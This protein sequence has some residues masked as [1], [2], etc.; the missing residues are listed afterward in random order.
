MAEQQLDVSM[1]VGWVEVLPSQVRRARVRSLG[2]EALGCAGCD[3][4]GCWADSNAAVCVYFPAVAAVFATSVFRCSGLCV[5]ARLCVCVLLLHLQEP[6]P[7]PEQEPQHE[8]RSRTFTASRS[9]VGGYEDG[10]AVDPVRIWVGSW[11]TAVN[12]CNCEELCGPMES[13]TPEAL[14]RML[15]TFAR[16]VPTDC[17]IYIMGLQEGSP[18]CEG[19]YF[20]SQLELYLRRLGVAHVPAA[21]GHPGKIYGRG[22]GSFISP[23]FTGIRVYCRSSSREH[24]SVVGAAGASAGINEGSK[25]AVGAL[26]RV[27]DTTLLAI[28]CHLAKHDMQKRRDQYGDICRK[29]AEGLAASSP[30]SSPSASTSPGASGLGPAAGGVGDLHSQYHHIIWFGDMNY[31][32][33]K[34][35]DGGCTPDE[36]ISCI[37]DGQLHALYPY[38]ELFEELDLIESPQNRRPLCFC[39]FSEPEKFVTGPLETRFY[40]TY[41]KDSKRGTAEAKG[42]RRFVVPHR[43][44]DIEAERDWVRRVYKIDYAEHW[45]KGGG[46]KLRMPSWTDRILYRSMPHLQSRFVPATR[47]DTDRYRAVNEVLLSSDHSPISCVFE[48]QPE[49]CRTEPHY[50]KMTVSNALAKYT[51]DTD[52]RWLAHCCGRKSTAALESLTCHGVCYFAQASQLRR[53][54]SSQELKQLRL[55]MRDASISRSSERTDDGQST[56]SFL[57]C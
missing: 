13:C 24:V 41:K 19:E 1:E 33:K 31:H 28:S 27:K 5:R 49:D 55:T 6:E 4:A 54:Q 10:A 35:K 37:R 25:G 47:N 51:R 30:L 39:G 23:K 26:I 32:V 50:S 15:D 29:L 42:G 46:V 22:D 7:E 40:P 17:E 16:F 11:N 48:L 44:A 18:D 56:T 2:W 20:F 57:H 52:V 3:A 38:D 12:E 53:A 34:A 9:R 21:N 43:E 8:L 14:Q 45:Y 36:A